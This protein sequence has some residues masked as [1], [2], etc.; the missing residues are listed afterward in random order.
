MLI[1]LSIKRKWMVS[2]WSENSSSMLETRQ[3]RL[4]FRHC[5]CKPQILRVDAVEWNV[6]MRSGSSRTNQGG[7]K[8]IS[9]YRRQMPCPCSGSLWATGCKGM[10]ECFEKA[11]LSMFILLN[12]CYCLTFILLLCSQPSWALLEDRGLAGLFLPWLFLWFTTLLKLMSAV[13]NLP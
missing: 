2:P 9:A 7:K 6:W 1:D 11:F 12:N 5:V 4:L 13:N 10:K 8:C 3:R